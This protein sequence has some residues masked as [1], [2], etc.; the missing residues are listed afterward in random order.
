M[1]LIKTLAYAGLGLSAENNEKLKDKF[2][3]LVEAGKKADTEGK[4]YIGD[5]FKTVDSTKDDFEANFE[6]NKEKL[7]EQFPVLK[8]LEE[9]LNQTKDEVTTKFNNTKADLTEKAKSAKED[10]TKK[11][12]DTKNEIESKIKNT[13]KK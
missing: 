11:A 13:S 8:E 9:K 3:E 6:K 4:N 5:F 2:N 12:N 1:D 10:I 7:M